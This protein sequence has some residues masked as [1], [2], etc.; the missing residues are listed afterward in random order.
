MAASLNTIPRNWVLFPDLQGYP[1]GEG[2]LC[3][4]SAFEPRRPEAEGDG[5][6]EGR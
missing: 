4:G 2:G 3:G 1:G 6:A 5:P